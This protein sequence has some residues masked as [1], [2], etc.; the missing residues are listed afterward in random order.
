MQIKYKNSFESD[1]YQNSPNTFTG[2][3]SFLYNTHYG[4]FI[5]FC[6]EELFRCVCLPANKC[7]MYCFESVSFNLRALLFYKWSKVARIASSCRLSLGCLNECMC[8][9]AIYQILYH[10][11]HHQQL[12]P[13]LDEV[14]CL[15][16][17]MIYY[18]KWKYWIKKLSMKW[19][20]T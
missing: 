8:W 17:I 20:L 2:W 10:A 11:F 18:F 13:K 9:I 3:G 4:N 16:S 15:A 19:T 12:L 14:Y 7:V 6:F 1:E 5:E